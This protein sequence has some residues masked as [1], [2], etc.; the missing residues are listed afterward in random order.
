M[1]A[2]R[3]AHDSHGG[4]ARRRPWAPVCW[5]VVVASVCVA[6]AAPL[7][8][9]WGPPSSVAEAEEG[10]WPFPD[11]PAD[12][13]FGED[14]GWMASRGLVMGSVDGTFGP[15]RPT[16]RQALAAVLYR[17]GRPL[18]RATPPTCG[19]APFLDVAPTHPFCG[20]IGAAVGAGWVRGLADGTF[21]PSASVARQDVVAVLWSLAGAPGGPGACEGTPF[22]DVDATDPFCEPVAWAA[23]V[24]VAFG[25]VDGRF[26]PEAPVTRQALA[27]LLARYERHQRAPVPSP[28][29]GAASPAVPV[30]E[31]RTDLDIDG[32]PRWFLHTVPSGHDGTSPRPLVV[33]LH[34]LAE[35]A[36]VHTRMSEASTTAER[37]GFVVAFPQGRFDPVRWDAED[38]TDANEDLRFIDEI[39]ATLGGDLCIDVSRVY[40]MGL[41]YGGFMTSLLV[42][43]RADTFAAVAPVAGLRALE[44][45]DQAATVPILSFHGTEDAILPFAPYEAAAATWASRNGCAPSPVDHVRTDEVTHRIWDCPAGADVEMF[46]LPG[47]GHSWPGS[48][49]SASIESVLGPTTMDIHATDEAWAFFERFDR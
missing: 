46:V 5:A 27:A 43:A 31:Q 21:A 12:H 41:S 33:D 37:E 8:L 22:G 39:L 48:E 20:P 23:E 42:C 14:I 2:C 30:V 35:G 34:G 36:L 7:P 4:F 28:G 44:P 40:A 32:S 29:C 9:R 15:A 6:L 49:F 26:A 16:T 13:P 3:A 10:S 47:G 19:T 17:Y 38:R 11:V 45:C 1:E 24:G 25:D 18:P